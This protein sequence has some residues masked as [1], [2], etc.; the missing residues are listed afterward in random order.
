MR[1]RQQEPHRCHRAVGGGADRLAVFLWRAADAAAAQQ[2]AATAQTAAGAAG[3]DAD[4]RRCPEPGRR[5]RGAG[6]GHRSR[7]S[8]GRRSSKPAR[9]R[10]PRS[11]RVA[12][13]TPAI[14]GSINLRGG[15]I[16]DVL[17]EELPR[18]RRPEEPEHRAVLAVGQPE[19]LLRRV[20][21]GRRRRPGALPGRRRRSGRPTARAHPASPVTLTWDNGQGLIFRRDD[22]AS[23]TSSCSRCKDAVENKGAAPVDA[24]P[25]RP[26][27]PARQADDAR[28]LRAARGPHRRSRRAGPAGI[29]LRQARQGRP[30]LRRRPRVGKVWDNVSRRLRRHH[31]Q[32][33]G[34][35]GR[36]RPD[37]AL[38]RAASRRGR[39]GPAKVYQANVLG[40]ARNARSPARRRE[41]DAAPV[42]RR[43]G[44]RG[45]RRAT[46]APT[47]SRTSTF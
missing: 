10:L 22:L 15:R 13:D 36:P 5:P 2:A 35:G 46:S 8:R 26:G 21:L 24:P 32:V 19:P 3:P 27:L 29:H 17:A 4:P 30:R 41:I 39:T 28:L 25:L 31:R 7:L 20:R 38:S 1:E 45:R 14:A 37:A 44:S 34:R 6:P 18:D 33:L 9:R 47:A 12:I 11:P 43:Q 16:D 40:D 23:T 42:R